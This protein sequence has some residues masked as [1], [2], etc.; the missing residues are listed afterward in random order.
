MTRA[1][2]NGFLAI[3]SDVDKAGET[4]YLHWLTREHVQERLAVPG[5]LA[6]RVFRT[7]AEGRARFLIFYR[8]KDA[9]VVGSAAYLARLNAPTAWSQRIM[10][11][12]KNFM[13]GGGRIVQESGSGEGMYAAPVLIERAQVSA[14]LDAGAEIAK[15]DKIAATR[16][17]EADP[18]ASG[19]AT[20][21]RAMRAGDRS[22]E[23]MLLL[24]ALD[25]NTLAAGLAVME[26]RDRSIYRQIFALRNA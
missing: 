2:A 15:A 12:L 17:F 14:Y 4:D 23:A 3:W 26:A 22:F 1:E 21:E 5:F 7:E 16:I 8:L 11:K 18:A 6:V 20:N 24:E 19:I 13:R 9:G 25:E 10:P